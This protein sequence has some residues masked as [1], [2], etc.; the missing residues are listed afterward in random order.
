MRLRYTLLPDGSSDAALLPLL[1]RVLRW[2]VPSVAVDEAWADLRRLPHPPKRLAERIQACMELYPC[3]VLFVH[4]D[5]ERVPREDRLY[6]IDE[7]VARA[8]ERIAIPPHVRVVPVRMRE[9]WLLADEEAI[10]RAASNPNGRDDL[11]LPPLADLE[12]LPD[13]KDVLYKALR[14]A[15]GLPS[16]RLRRFS[17]AKCAFQIPHHMHDMTILRGLPAFQQLEADVT[18]VVEAAGWGIPDGM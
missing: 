2:Y 9:A 13:P 10:R 18:R 8:R 4:R 7:A 15:S 12:S 17:A 6:E 16:G 1:T 14:Q 5:A 11:D 3:D